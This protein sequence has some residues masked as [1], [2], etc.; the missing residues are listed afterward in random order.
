MIT[1]ARLSA[2]ISINNVDQCYDLEN[3]TGKVRNIP[4]AS[5]FSNSQLSN[6]NIAK[7]A[8]KLGG[9]NGFYGNFYGI[10]DT[11]SS[12]NSVAPTGNKNR[13]FKLSLPITF[14][15]SGRLKFMTLSGSDFAQVS[16]DSTNPAYSANT[17]LGSSFNGQNGFEIITTGTLDFSN[18]QWLRARICREDDNS[19]TC[20][21]RNPTSIP[22]TPNIVD[23]NFNGAIAQKDSTSSLYDFD[24]SGHLLRS[25]L[26]GTNDCTTQNSG[27]QTDIN[28]PF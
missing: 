20:S 22:N 3:Y 8:I 10:S 18:G 13:I 14:S 9:F 6:A 21:N 24:E 23:F 12:A 2:Y 26:P 4:L 16:P 7:G 17:S 28:Q 27:T 15:N 5:G 25:T 1:K 11:K 19:Y